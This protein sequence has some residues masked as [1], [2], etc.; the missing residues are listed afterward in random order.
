MI[1]VSICAEFKIIAGGDHEKQLRIPAT[2]INAHNRSLWGS[3]NS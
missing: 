2:R 3:N 1:A